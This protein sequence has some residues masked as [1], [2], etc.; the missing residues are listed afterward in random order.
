MFDE[1]TSNLDSQSEHLVQESI[2]NALKNSTGLVI[3]HR[4]STN[5]K[6][7]KIIFLNNG[8]IEAMWGI[9]PHAINYEKWYY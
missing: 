5:I 4:L 8:R 7:D 6:A 3:A 9:M 1:G 2:E